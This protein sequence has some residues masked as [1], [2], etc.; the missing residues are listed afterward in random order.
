[1]IRRDNTD[2]EI[3]PYNYEELRS[4]ISWLDERLV[5]YSLVKKPI[6]TDFPVAINMRNEDAI[7]FKLVFGL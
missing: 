2:V 4:Y 6:W 3:G 7:A 5:K 1:M